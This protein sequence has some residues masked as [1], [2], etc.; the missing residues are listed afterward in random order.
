M[1]TAE[2]PLKK[3]KLY[4]PQQEEPTRKPPQTLAEPER[5]VAPPTTP[6][7]LSQDEILARRR[8]KEEIRNVY[9]GYKRIKA[10]VAIKDA[11]HM[12][13][14]EQAYLSLIT[15]SRGCTS[16]QR[17]VADL[18]PRYAQYCPTALEAAA[19]V[20]IN[21]HNCCLAVINRGEDTDGVASQTAKACSFGLVDICLAATLEAPSS[22]VIQDISTI[23][24]ALE[25]IFKSFSGQNNIGESEVDSD[26]EDSNHSTYINGQYLVPNFSN[27]KQT[28]GELSGNKNLRNHVGSADTFADK[29]SGQYLRPHSSIVPFESDIRS[30]AGSSYDSGGPRSM[31]FETC[32]HGDLSHSRSSMPRDLLNHQMLSSVARTQSDFRSNS[33]DCKNHFVPA[34]KNQISNTDY[35]L[36]SPRS[37]SGG[38]SNVLASPGHHFPLPYSSTTFQTVWHFD[39]DPTSMDIYSASK[40]LLIGS[41][42]PDASE[43]HV[44]FQLER[45]GPLEQFHFF[46][47]KSFALAEYRS[48]IDAIRAREYVRGQFPWCIKFMDSGVGTRGSMNGVAVG[49]SSHV[50]VGNISSQWAKDEILH[51]SRKVLYK[52]PYMVTDLCSEGGMLLEFET[53]EEASTVMAHLRQYRK[54]RSNYLPPFNAGPPNVARSVPAP[55]HLDIRTN[56][57]ANM[58]S[59]IIGSPHDHSV[60]E[61][62]ADSCRTKMSHLSSLFS[63]LRAKYN[64]SHTSSHFDNY[65]PWNCRGGGLREEDRIPSSTLWISLPNSSSLFLTD[66]ELMTI[67]NLAIA[68]IGSVFRLT[69]ASMQMG[70]GWFVECSSID[71]AITVLN[72]LRGCPGMFFRIEFS[73]P[74]KHHGAPFSMRT[75]SNTMDLVS[76]R[77]KSENL[78]NA[79]QT[80]AHPP[81]IQ[82]LHFNYILH[83]HVSIT[84]LHMWTYNKFAIELHSAT[85]SMPCIPR[86]TLGHSVPP[87]PQIQAPPYIRP[88]YLPPNNSWDAQGFSHQMP[89]NPVARGVMSNTFHSNAVAAPFVPASVT[90]LAQIQG[91]PMQRFDQM[92]SVPVVP[93]PLPSLPPQPEMLPPLPPSPP[94]LPQSQPPVVPPPPSSPP[95]P[96]PPP[97]PAP[98]AK[99]TEVESSG[100]CVQFQWQGIL[101]KSGVHY[102]KIYALRV[103]SDICRY[104]NAISEPAEWPAKLDMTKRTDFRHVK[105]TFTNTPPHKREVCRLVPCSTAD[106]KGFQ[107]F[108]SYL[109]QRECAGVIK[110]PAVKSLWARLLFILPYS[111]DTCSMLSI[112]PKPSD[113]LIALVLPKET[114]FDWRA[115]VRAANQRRNPSIW[116]WLIVI[117]TTQMTKEK[118]A[119]MIH[120]L[121]HHKT[122]NPDTLS[123]SLRRSFTHAT[124]SS[125]TARYGNFVNYLPQDEA[126]AAGLAP[127]DGASDPVESQRV[128]DVLNRE[129]SRLLKLNPRYFWREV[130]S[131]TSLHEFLDT[132]LKFRSRWYDF[133]YHGFKGIVAGVIVGELELNRRVFMLLYRISSNRDPGARAAESLSLKDHEVILQE[134]RLLDLPKLL[135]ICAIYGHENEDLTRLLVENAIKAQPRI[136]DNLTAVMSH[137]LSIVHTMHQ[138]C[139]SFL[140]ALFS[141]KSHEDHGSIRIRTDLLEVMDFLNDAVVSMDAFVFAYKPAAVFFSCPVETSHGNEEVLGILARLHD[142]LLPSLR[143]GFQIIFTSEE[144]G[145]ISNIAVSL[146]MLSM[147]IVNFGWKLFDICYLNEVTFEDGLPM[148]SVTKIFPAKV[149]DPVIRA[150]ILVQTFREISGVILQLQ[151]N[152]NGNTFLHNLEKNY[153]IMSRLESLTNSGW[154]FMD[155]EQFQYLSGI[156]VYAPR[157]NVKGP[158]IMALPSTS[159][160]VQID[161]DSAIKESK[162][163]QIKDLFPDYGKGFLSA[164]LEVYNQNPE[165]VIQRILEGTLHEDLQCL[166][167][168]LQTIPTSISA[169]TANRRDKGKGKLVE[170]SEVHSTKISSSNPHLLHGEQQVANLSV[171][172]SSTVGRFIRKSRVDL[173]NPSTLDIRDEMDVAKTA[174][175][176]SQYEYEDEYDDS[177]DDLGLSVGGSGL[178]ESEISTDRISSNFGKPWETA[179]SLADAAPKWGSRKQ[180][181]YYVKDGK[182]YSYK[183]AGSVAVAN[184]SE[185]SLVNQSQKELIYGLGRG[186]NLPLGAVKKLMEYENQDNKS[187]AS[188]MEE[189]GSTRNPRGRGRRG[190]GRQRESPEEPEHHSDSVEVE[191]RGNVGNQ[192]GRGRRGGG[193]RNHHRKDQAM[194]KHFSGLTGF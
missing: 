134:K 122:Q 105:S 113:C 3:R 81:I 25:G 194:K 111:H 171:S 49:S 6:P 175:L 12:L 127:E 100:L 156:M 27:Q 152:Q 51:E 98:A 132:F 72:N 87:P 176:L 169:L 148:P 64:I 121:A 19:K 93:P 11:R 48:I 42:G 35:S 89:L 180:P 97:P 66:D 107:D 30:T 95:P 191:G 54:E 108:I 67:C 8:N 41:L 60:T 119:T 34:D 36:P 173:P 75:E 116:L 62:P 96:P 7:P 164:C 88:V 133:P 172:S 57:P 178:E 150:D 114:N 91:A 29:F 167:T 46:P 20:V 149:E 161:E 183:V 82:L 78:V 145:M 50:Y 190:G 124:T 22:S 61:S 45:F 192:R 168:S 144:D 94:P 77:V 17:I 118:E 18:V 170:S 28:S 163:S 74:G 26:Q 106:L 129:L 182:N 181:Q 104:S 157:G 140:E 68:N 143:R 187:D 31:D 110:V 9:E 71:A 131:D 147:R 193:G 126:V 103:D 1:A 37:S 141:S 79:V 10:C 52:G 146:K 44:R 162:I 189:K 39:G 32:D 158:P 5:S 56:N 65:T 128:V 70:N 92:Y 166:N 24:S 115:C 15:A 86:A 185:A 142:S 43:G 188:E 117:H 59:S 53:P 80:V 90:P 76:P 186:G 73:P 184:A 136:Y 99:S 101:C 4:E 85:G 55:F 174:A 137:F 130:A 58:S 14:L 165:E 84:V 23:T 153:N 16:V 123:S 102:C 33:F 40:Q 179:V 160:Q 138:R 21:M 177:F 120:T 83:R 159:N 63:S 2:Q 38:A 47:V 125:S 151:E 135:D 112:A 69:R 109:K 154:I 13:E 155:D 139:S